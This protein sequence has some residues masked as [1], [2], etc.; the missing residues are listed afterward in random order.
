[1]IRNSYLL[2]ILISLFT[3]RAYAGPDVVYACMKN[4]QNVA[5]CS[6]SCSASYGVI[7]PSPQPPNPPNIVG[8]SFS[9]PDAMRI[10]FYN[11]MTD[12]QRDTRTWVMWES[13]H[14]LGVI[15]LGAGDH[16]GWTTSKAPDAA[17]FAIQ[18]KFDQ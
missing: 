6:F 5:E 12:G 8:G 15:Y 11:R 3:T 17:G 13:A 16:C 14:N 4:G 7:E 2:I 1:M 18:G 10:Q 9:V